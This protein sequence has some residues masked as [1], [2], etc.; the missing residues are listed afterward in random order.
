MPR[1]TA[2]RTAD[3]P[4][5]GLRG[6]PEQAV[7]PVAQPRGWPFPRGS[8]NH[9]DETS[10]PWPRPRRPASTQPQPAQPQPADPADQ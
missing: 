9:L 4:R 6:T 2:P 8:Q 5:P 10:A 1:P 7:Q 3:S